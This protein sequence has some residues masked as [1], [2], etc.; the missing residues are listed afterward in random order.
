MATSPHLVWPD[1]R[2]LRS[3]REPQREGHQDKRYAHQRSTRASSAGQLSVRHLGLRRSPRLFPLSQPGQQFSIAHVVLPATGLLLGM[4]CLAS[5]IAL[6]DGQASLLA[7][8]SELL[9]VAL[10]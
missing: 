10:P 9:D 6:T 8:L 3:S 5:F 2:Y 7:S 1:A 4:Q